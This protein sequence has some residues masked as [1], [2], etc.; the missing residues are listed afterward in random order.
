MLKAFGGSA[1]LTDLCCVSFSEKFTGIE[2]ARDEV[3][4][5]K[6]LQKQEVKEA[7]LKSDTEL[8]DIPEP[9]AKLVVNGKL[10]PM[11]LE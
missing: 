2:D 9:T 10:Y 1:K 3:R 11:K 7:F 8:D 6:L 5:A 4:M